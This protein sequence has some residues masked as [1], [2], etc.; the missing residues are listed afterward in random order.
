MESLVFERR[1]TFRDACIVLL[2]LVVVICVVW[3]EWNRMYREVLF[4]VFERRSRSR[5]M[6]VII[7]FLVIGS[8]F[9]KQWHWVSR[10]EKAFRVVGLCSLLFLFI[11]SKIV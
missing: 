5:D 7:S 2:F 4:L 10:K 3:L 1:Y 11:V 8:C 6:Y 9:W